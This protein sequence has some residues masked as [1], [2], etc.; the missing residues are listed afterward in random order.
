MK[1]YKQ[2]IFGFLFF[3]FLGLNLA[4]LA[5]NAGNFGNYGLD[6]TVSIPNT[7]VASAL[8]VG[9]VGSSPSYF[10]T[11]RIGKMIGA[12][13][14]FVGVIFLALMIYAG[15]RWMTAAG[16]EASVDKAKNLIIAAIIGLIIIL[17]AYAI[18]AWI[19]TNLL[20]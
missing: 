7:N 13:L 17:G 2:I 3:V 15:F 1:K 5:V 4:P 9:A 12:V 18:T 14:A 16:N 20:K 19:G 8:S 11:S 10:L 6:G